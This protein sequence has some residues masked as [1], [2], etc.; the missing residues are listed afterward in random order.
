MYGFMAI[1]L[2]SH[3]KWPAPERVRLKVGSKLSSCNLT[4]ESNQTA[5]G[6]EMSFLSVALV[7]ALFFYFHFYCSSHLFVSEPCKRK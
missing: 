2:T 6:T 7:I 1:D 3:A 4:N 5:V